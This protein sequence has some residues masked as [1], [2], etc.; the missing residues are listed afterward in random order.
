MLTSRLAVVHHLPSAIRACTGSRC[1]QPVTD[2]NA[3]PSA[4]QTAKIRIGLDL[5]FTGLMNRPQP[6]HPTLLAL[7][8]MNEDGQRTARIRRRP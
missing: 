6:H 5:W 2:P 4:M 8:L 3:I 1:D 7:E